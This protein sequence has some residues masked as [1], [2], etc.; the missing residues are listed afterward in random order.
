MLCVISVVAW[1]SPVAVRTCSFE[2]FKGL[3]NA[4]IDDSNG[5][6]RK[7]TKSLPSRTQSGLDGSVLDMRKKVAAEKAMKKAEEA[8]RLR[9]Q[10]AEMK[11]RIMAQGKGRD[12]KELDAEVEAKRKEMAKARAAIKVRATARCWAPTAPMHHAWP[13]TL[14]R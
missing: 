13:K 12:P 8:E 1:S 2:E 3:Y 9:K 6:K 5:K 14:L 11:S 7:D 4:A 10:N